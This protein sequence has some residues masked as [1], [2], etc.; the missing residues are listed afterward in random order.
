MA[1]IVISLYFCLDS[2]TINQL[3]NLV[4][5]GLC[6]SCPSAGTSVYILSLS[7]LSCGLSSQAET[8]GSALIWPHDQGEN[9]PW[10]SRVPDNKKGGGEHS[11]HPHDVVMSKMGEVRFPAQG[12]GDAIIRATVR[13]L[14]SWGPL[15]SLPS[16][17]ALVGC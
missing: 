2:S 14:D 12:H 5:S 10:V 1:T 6:L 7:S 11:S 9:L 16:P 8:I 13:L 15:F 4:A 3:P 17:K